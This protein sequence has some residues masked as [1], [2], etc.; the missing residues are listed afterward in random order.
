MKQYL[1]LSQLEEGTIPSNNAHKIAHK[2]Y[3]LHLSLA[4]THVYVC[5]T[6]LARLTHFG[7]SKLETLAADPNTPF[8]TLIEKASINH[9]KKKD[10][11]NAW[12]DE[13][14]VPVCEPDE[15]YPSFLRCEKYETVSAVKENYDQYLVSSFD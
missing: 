3:I 13:Y 11:L 7:L 15:T 10:I 5:P 8:N 1:L 14:V 2:N 6:A 12:V 4:D 9:T